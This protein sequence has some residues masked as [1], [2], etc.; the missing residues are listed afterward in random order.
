MFW[1]KGA[2]ELYASDE[3]GYIYIINVYQE[4]K[5]VTKDLCR[6]GLSEKKKMKDLDK[7]EGRIRI[8]KIEI[9]DDRLDRKCLLVHTDAGVKSYRIRK[10]VKK[11]DMVG[12]SGP[13][14]KIIALEPSKLERL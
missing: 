11:H 8:N 3:K 2:Q 4:D 10:G 1:D 14:L 7:N 13:I 12:H 5:I 6:A 9:I